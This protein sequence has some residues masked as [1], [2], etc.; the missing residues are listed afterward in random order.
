MTES[1]PRRSVSELVALYRVEPDLCDF[2]VEGRADKVFL[3]NS[4][5]GCHVVEIESIDI[6]SILVSQA[7]LTSGSKQRLT[8]LAAEL[9]AL[10]PI[11]AGTH[12][13]CVVDADFDRIFGREVSAS[14]FLRYT[15]FSCLES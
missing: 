8:V 11:N 15:D 6:P 7:G 14:R 4:V 12:V 1:I 2:Y 3:E 13:R 9:E 10:I 5:P